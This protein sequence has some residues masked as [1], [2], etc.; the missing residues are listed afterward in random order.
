MLLTIH[1]PDK[2]QRIAF[3]ADLKHILNVAKVKSQDYIPGRSNGRSADIG[4]KA[5]KISIE[6]LAQVLSQ[7]ERRGYSVESTKGPEALSLSLSAFSPQETQ[8]T[9]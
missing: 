9:T 2:L 6:V 7:I 5:D 3:A 4:L 8:K 1:I